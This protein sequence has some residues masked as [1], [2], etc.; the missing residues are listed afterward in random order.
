[1]RL[2]KGAEAGDSTGL[3]E[4][5]GDLLFAVI[6]PTRL[7]GSHPTT[8]LARANTKFCNRFEFLEK[9]A[10]DLALLSRNLA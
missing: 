5:L 6:N 7:A 8:G 4:E 2:R 10:R 9:L 1:M 3:E